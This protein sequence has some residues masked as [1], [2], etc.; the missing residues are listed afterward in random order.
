MLDILLYI[1]YNVCSVTKK[2]ESMRPASN[3]NGTHGGH[4]S[5][6]VRTDHGVFAVYITGNHNDTTYGYSWDEFTVFK[7]NNST[8]DQ[9]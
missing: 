9:I 8:H 2:G 6:V 4:E 3:A 7:L 1:L 5:R